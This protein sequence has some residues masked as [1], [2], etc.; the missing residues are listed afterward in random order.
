M[1]GT[2][3]SVQCLVRLTIV[4]CTLFVSTA[5]QASTDFRVAG[6]VDSTNKQKLS[7]VIELPN[8]EQRLVREGQDLPEFTVIRITRN[9][10]RLA[11]D[12]GERV[13]RLTGGGFQQVTQGIEHEVPP[14]IENRTLTAAV[15]EQL[16]RMR[17]EQAAS[18]LNKVLG[19][20]KNVVIT[21]VLPEAVESPQEALASIQA[22]LGRGEFVH[23]FLTGTDELGELYLMPEPGE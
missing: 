8:G 2:A 9:E 20:P 7:A 12:D 23:L 17:P 13:Y 11:F 15:R 1:K 18:Q 10:V 4:L 5:L 21:M 19:L 14:P 22:T 3:H 16:E 6:I